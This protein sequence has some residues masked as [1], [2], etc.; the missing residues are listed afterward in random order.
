MVNTASMA[1]HISI[2]M[3]A[4]YHASK[5]AVVTISE[6]LHYELALVGA[7]VKASVLCPGFVKTRIME[8]ERNRPAGLKTPDRVVSENERAFL[9][10]YREFVGA[11]LPPSDVAGKV[12]DA[13]RDERFW[14]F[15][16]PETLDSVRTRMDSVLS[17]TNPVF[18]PPG[19]MKERL[20]M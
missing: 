5:F 1:G 16:H 9:S 17:E 2:P 20:G 14:V 15:P 8:S 3:F 19:G 13:I 7:K 11:G 4:P 12:V 18:A 10:A 6:T